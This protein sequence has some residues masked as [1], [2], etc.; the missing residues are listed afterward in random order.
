M[1]LCGCGP[2][3]AIEHNDLT[4]AA[5][6]VL[7]LMGQRGQVWCILSTHAR[8]WL[9]PITRLAEQELATRSELRLETS[10]L[11]G[12]EPGA[13]WAEMLGFEREA[14]MRAYYD[15]ADY[16]LYARVRHG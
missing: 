8:H 2:A 12:F 3:H 16:W 15:G 5:W 13:R 14:L 6:G 1:D 10:V 11:V 9:L 4:M 7:P